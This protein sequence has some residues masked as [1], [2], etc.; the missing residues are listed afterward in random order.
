MQARLLGLINNY[1]E[2]EPVGFL[3]LRINV[4]DNIFEGWACCQ[5]DGVVR[6]STE[7]M[8]VPVHGQKTFI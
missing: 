3:Y 7:N 5:I 6:K 1:E 2:E 4:F 8:E